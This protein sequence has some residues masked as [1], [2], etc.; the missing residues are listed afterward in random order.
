[1]EALASPVLILDD[2]RSVFN[3]GSMY[4]VSDCV[5]VSEAWLCG[6]TPGP[7]DRFGMPRRDFNKVSL[8]AETTV[9]T[10]RFETTLDAVTEAKKRGYV[11]VAIEQ[12][13]D[14]VDY[15]K[16]AE[17][18]AHDHAGKPIAFVVGRE[19]EGL[20]ADV[21]AECD[22]IAEIPL[23]GQKESLNVAVA[24]AVAAFRILGR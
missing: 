22:V 7:L 15:K 17:V 16:V 24:F 23:A 20:S 1:M 13:P 3:V 10:H 9:A 4:R 8:G 19:V 5:G 2:I 6:V 11:V 12:S 18:L 21:L 14:S